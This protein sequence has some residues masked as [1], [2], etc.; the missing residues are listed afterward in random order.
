MKKNILLLLLLANIHVLAQPE[1]VDRI[2]YKLES[3]ADIDIGWMKTY[4][5]TAAPK[6]KTLGNRIYSAK[7]IGYTQQFV[8]I[9]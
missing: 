6:G 8:E 7:Q 1:Y 5:H 9:E 4:K 3:I 2:G